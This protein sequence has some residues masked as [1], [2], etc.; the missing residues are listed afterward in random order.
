MAHDP[1]LSTYVLRNHILRTLFASRNPHTVW[2]K[3]HGSRPPLHSPFK[4]KDPI[5]ASDLNAKNE[6]V[7]APGYSPRGGLAPSTIAAGGLNCCV[8]NGNRCGPAAPG[9]KT[10]PSFRLVDCWWWFLI[11]Q[12]VPINFLTGIHMPT[13][14]PIT[15]NYEP[16]I[17]P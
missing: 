9:T 7:L 17:R 3:A 16:S 2:R 12:L 4:Q 5:D 10:M 8:R 15:T 6:T 11:L 13:S 14:K 1:Y